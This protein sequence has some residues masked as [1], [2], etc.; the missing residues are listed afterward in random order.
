MPTSS[1]TAPDDAIV[2]DVAD[3]L[4]RSTMRLARILRQEDT[5]DLSP[6]LA[7]VLFTIDRHGP[8][9]LGELARRE[10]LTKPSVTASIDKLLTRGLI[11]RSIDEHDRRIVR[12]T[13]TAAGRRRVS[14]RRSLRTAWLAARLRELPAADVQRLRDATEV[15]ER[16]VAEAT[17]E[18]DR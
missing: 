5:D 7:S 2:V 11:D 6:T 13:L 18:T 8:V 17:Q 4:R 10:R 14:A 15:L 3:R 16:I 1:K 9:T 12:V